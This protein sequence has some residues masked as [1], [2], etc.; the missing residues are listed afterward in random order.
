MQLL[1]EDWEGIRNLVMALPRTLSRF[2]LVSS[3][4][5]TKYNELPWRYLFLDFYDLRIIHEVVL[6]F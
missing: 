2:V 1:V 6:L 3:V 4:G 5:V